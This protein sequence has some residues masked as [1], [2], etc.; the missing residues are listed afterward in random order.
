M[1]ERKHQPKMSPK[2]SKTIR[3]RVWDDPGGSR[4][5]LGDH[6]GP[7]GPK[8]HKGDQTAA[9]YL[10]VFGTELET[11]SNFSWACFLVLFEVLVFEIVHDFGYPILASL[12]LL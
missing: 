6:L 3:N 11:W 9:K 7:G 12:V 2:A 10:S 1:G 4:E 8:A 5:R